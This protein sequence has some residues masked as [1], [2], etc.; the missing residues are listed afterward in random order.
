MYIYQ[1]QSNNVTFKGGA[2]KGYE[3]ARHHK[4]ANF[5]NKENRDTASQLIDV[6]DDSQSDQSL[7][8]H[9]A[10]SNRDGQNAVD[11][12]DWT[13]RTEHQ[14]PT[15]HLDMGASNWMNKDGYL[16]NEFLTEL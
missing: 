8:S 16:S 10:S 1:K 13:R 5:E 3:A 6:E 15:Q 11:V 9:S 7:T 2:Q 4:V 14:T 12:E